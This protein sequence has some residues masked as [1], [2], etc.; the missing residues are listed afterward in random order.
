M[1]DATCALACWGNAAIMKRVLFRY[2]AKVALYVLIVQ[3]GLGG[4]DCRCCSSTARRP[5]R[6]RLARFDAGTAISNAGAMANDNGLLIA[7]SPTQQSSSVHG[8]QGFRSDMSI[9]HHI[10]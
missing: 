1:T 9:S 3:D 4:C 7:I 2:D 8:F 10:P 6:F 5:R